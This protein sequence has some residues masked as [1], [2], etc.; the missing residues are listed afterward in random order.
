VST[1]ID[2]GVDLR[3]EVLVPAG[4]PPGPATARGTSRIVFAAP[5]RMKLEVEAPGRGYLGILE[6]HDH[7]WRAIV[8]GRPASMV[9]ANV[10]FRGIRLYPGARAVDLVYR[11]PGLVAGLVLS[12]LSILAAFVL[13]WRTSRPR[14]VTREAP[15]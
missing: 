4:A 10:L 9:A 5:D 15:P 6:S 8:D 14:G 13:A 12:A 3:S 7:G 1:L 11:P 2:P